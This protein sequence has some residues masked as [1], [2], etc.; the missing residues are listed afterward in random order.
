MNSISTLTEFR[1]RLGKNAL[2]KF[3]CGFNDSVGKLQIK[4]RTNYS[5]FLCVFFFFNL[6]SK[7][8]PKDKKD[9]FSFE[10]IGFEIPLHYTST[11]ESTN[12]KDI[13]KALS[14]ATDYMREKARRL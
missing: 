12:E 14:R 9:D 4:R 3:P 5:P 2:I 11:E 6:E 10:Y 13:I 7:S 1:F 8:K